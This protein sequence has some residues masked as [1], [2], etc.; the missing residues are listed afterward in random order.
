MTQRTLLTRGAL[1]SQQITL[2][3]SIYT[4]VTASPWKR[5]HRAMSSTSIPPPA[6]L[7]QPFEAPYRHMFGPG[8]SD[9]P[10]RV[11]A[12][13]GRPIIGHM[14][15]EMF[16]IM[17]HI[18]KGIQYAFQTQNNMTIAMSGSGHTAMECAIFNSVEP[19]ESVLMAVNG[20]WGERAAEI[21]ERIGAKVNTII[22]APGSSFT[23]EE[24]EEALAKH[25]PVLFF[26]THGESSSG[27]AHPID[28]IGDLCLRHNCLFL[29]DAVASLGGSPLYMDKQG[30]DILYSGSQKVL[31]SPPG[32]AP[33]SFSERA[34][35]K[36]F[37]RKTKPVSYLLDMTWLANYWGC[38]GKP[39]RMYHHTGPVSGFFTLRESL[40][41]LVETGLENSWQRHKDV[42]EHFHKGLEDLGLKLFVEDK[43]VRLPTVT[44]I[45]VPAGYDWKE[46]VAYV[47]KHHQIEISG[48]LG[49]S[50][51]KVLRVGLMGCNSSIANADMVLAALGDA[52]K[53]CH[54]SKV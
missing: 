20:I 37:N 53:C 33:I 38:D 23:N 21:A 29:V 48:G 2:G 28:G 41:I 47:M 27:V 16:E 39:A 19:G 4:A 24:I 40:A 32:T 34:C 6:C 3:S 14:H 49:P 26:L 46:I 50:A 22:T 8:P 43:N 10:P 44:T 31:N 52:L 9:V 42:A 18:K 36:I 17:D 45:V 25:K 7:L 15:K 5:F 35:K 1:L 54:R 11:L 13:G 12:A 51:G 30:I